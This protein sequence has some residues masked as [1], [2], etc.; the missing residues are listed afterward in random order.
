MLDYEVDWATTWSG[1]SAGAATLT[2]I[3]AAL[4]AIIGLRQ[5]KQARDLNEEQSRPYIVI[6]LQPTEADRSLLNFVIQNIGQTAARNISIKFEPEFS[7]A[8][9]LPGHDFMNAK[10][11]SEPIPSMPP[12]FEYRMIFE[13]ISDYQKL[14]NP[15]SSYTVNVRY[16]DR[17][18]KKLT[19]S[20]TLDLEAMRGSITVDTHG[21]HHI[22]KT[23]RAWAKSEGTSS[24]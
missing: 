7:R 8:M 23:L 4:A 13:N 3:I 18:G 14:D 10:L 19:D 22:A 24:F 20:F 5:L 9:K 1:V 17:Q 21:L 16:E 2:L 11:I 6:Y 15:R 12:Q